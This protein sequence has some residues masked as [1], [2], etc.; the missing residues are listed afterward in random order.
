MPRL[1]KQRPVYI[2]VPKALNKFGPGFF[3]LLER[4]DNLGLLIVQETTTG[5]IFKMTPLCLQKMLL[6]EKW[7]ITLKKP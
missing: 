7:D 3:M 6:S 4:D 1:K 2:I 5:D